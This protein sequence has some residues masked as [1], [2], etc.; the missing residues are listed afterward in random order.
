MWPYRSSGNNHFMEETV[1]KQTK[2]VQ[3]KATAD[4]ILMTQDRASAILSPTMK[5][6]GTVSKDDVAA[7]AI[8]AS[9]RTSKA[10]GGR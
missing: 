10:G 6:Q 9:A 2:A 8:R 1:T 4:K 7:H 5:D 3:G